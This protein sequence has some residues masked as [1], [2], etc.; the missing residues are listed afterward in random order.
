V[1]TFR[2]DGKHVVITGASSGFG[3]HFAGV[4]A[5]AGAKVVLGA[6]RVD[7][8]EARVEEIRQAGGQAAG[9]PL[10]VRSA[11]S[12]RGFLEEAERTF[13]PI[14]VV[15]NNAGVEAGAKT[16]MMIDEDDWDFVMETNLKGPWL[17]AKFYTERVVAN[18]QKSGNIVNISSI[19]DT[20]TIK[21]QFPYAVSKGALTR[22]TEVLALEAAKYGIRVNALAPGY[23]LTDVSRLLLESDTAPEFMKGIPMRRFGNFDDL[24]GPILL[25]ASDGSRYMTGSVIVVDGGHICASL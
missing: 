4:L 5:A 11:D 20:R 17:M 7:K 24:D 9:L 22:M 8:V 25:L 10:D 12:I 18:R 23:I 21:G 6:R 19:T 1:E 3:H 14:D 13:G 2:L 16:Y 15:I